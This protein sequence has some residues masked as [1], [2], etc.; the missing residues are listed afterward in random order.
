MFSGIEH[1][2]IAYDDPMTPQITVFSAAILAG[3]RSRRFGRDKALAPYHGKP[4]L[5][6]VLESLSEADERLI[7]ANRPY[8]L[9][10]IRRIADIIPTSSSLSGLHAALA[11]AKH[12]WVAVA[13][14]DLPHLRPSF[15]RLLRRHSGPWDAVMVRHD[16]GRLEPLAALYHRSVLSMVETQLQRGDLSLHHLARNLNTRYLRARTVYSATSL[17]VLLNVNTVSDLAQP[18]HQ[19]R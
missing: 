1:R 5:Q 19:P 17:R 12:Q 2:A 8:P 16:S 7:I 14:C 13:A 3:G 9:F 18:H 10:G 11:S 6:W 4:L 15:W